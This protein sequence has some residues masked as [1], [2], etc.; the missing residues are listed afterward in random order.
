MPA[1]GV[2]IVFPTSGIFIT[3]GVFIGKI[4]WNGSNTWISKVTRENE[5]L[6]EVRL[7]PSDSVASIDIW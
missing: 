6:V 2:F 1:W 7:S 4:L 3:E 5:Y